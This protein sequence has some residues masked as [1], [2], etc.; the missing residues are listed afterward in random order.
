MSDTSLPV[1]AEIWA[2]SIFKTAVAK[3]NTCW[4]GVVQAD[5]LQPGL[6]AGGFLLC[7]LFN[8]A[9][10]CGCKRVFPWVFLS[11]VPSPIFLLLAAA[12]QVPSGEL[13]NPSSQAMFEY[14]DL[15]IPEGLSPKPGCLSQQHVP[16]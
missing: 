16:F 10:P 7:L 12:L 2:C 11:L 6:W 4:V 3:A 8:L 9:Y 1:S 14:L 5:S 13:P 15:A